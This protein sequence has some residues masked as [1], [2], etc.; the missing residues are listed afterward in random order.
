MCFIASP[1]T[2]TF[3]SDFEIPRRRSE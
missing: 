3:E 1:D 2:N